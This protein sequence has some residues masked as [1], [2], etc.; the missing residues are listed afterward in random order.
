M[1]IAKI[2][3]TQNNDICIELIPYFTSATQVPMPEI[4]GFKYFL[5][6]SDTQ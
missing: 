5:D 4:E 2:K 6:N 3:E 1:E